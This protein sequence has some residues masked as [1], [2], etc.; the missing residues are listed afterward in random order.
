[1][2]E[3]GTVV[4]KNGRCWE[5]DLVERKKRGRLKK[6][7]SFIGLLS[8]SFTNCHVSAYLR[9]VST[10]F[11]VL[12]AHRSLRLSRQSGR[13]LR[14]SPFAK[15]QIYRPCNFGSDHDVALAQHWRGNTS[16]LAQHGRSID[17]KLM[18]WFETITPSKDNYLLKNRNNK[19]KLLN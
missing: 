4:K 19:R 13:E 14:H 16:T 1:M 3:V 6:S 11:S 7:D 9:S 8:R 10:S 18:S 17:A 15:K 2:G 12:G 5:I